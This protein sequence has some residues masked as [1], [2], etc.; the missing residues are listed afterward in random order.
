MEVLIPFS[1]SEQDLVKCEK[2]SSYVGRL[3]SEV[4]NLIGK[5]K[6]VR[7]KSS[8]PGNGD[9]DF[10]DNASVCSSL[11]SASEHSIKVSKKVKKVKRPPCELHPKSG[12]SKTTSSL[13]DDKSKDDK[14]KE[15]ND[16]VPSSESTGTGICTCRKSKSEGK[17]R[18]KSRVKRP[19]PEG[20]L[21]TNP[22][23]GQILDEFERVI[24]SDERMFSDL[25]EDPVI[26][27]QIRAESERFHKR[28][29]TAD[30]D[31]IFSAIQMLNTN[32]MIK[33]AILQTE[34]KNIKDVSLKRVYINICC[35]RF[36]GVP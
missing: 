28:I 22:F 20:G 25:E 12:D 13:P 26:D 3:N 8:K 1:N 19:E 27:E 24:Y 23:K 32:T 9:D 17:S 10:D 7:N 34:L 35:H 4:L 36:P 15:E 16:K 2:E 30:G 29:G 5:H 31:N 18:E 33:F 6:K 14:N 21:I 11:S